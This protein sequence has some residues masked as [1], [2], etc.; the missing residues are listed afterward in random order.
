M[1]LLLVGDL[2]KVI[3]AVADAVL[4]TINFDCGIPGQ[5]RNVKFLWH[6]ILFL[7]LFTH[8]NFTHES[9]QLAQER[10]LWDCSH[11]PG[12]VCCCVL[13][14]EE[15]RFLGLAV[16][17]VLLMGIFIEHRL[18]PPEIVVKQDGAGGDQQPPIL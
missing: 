16:I 4:K 8:H 11:N 14:D 10:I 3:D 15:G 7:E 1:F 9:E 17:V 6:S 12:I 18:Y 2:E 5:P 13:G